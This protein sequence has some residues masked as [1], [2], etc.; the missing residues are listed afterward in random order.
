MRTP[1]SVGIPAFNEEKNIRK[2]LTSLLQQ[3]TERIDID[4]IIV[5]SS[6]SSDRTDMIVDEF[7]ER[8]EKVKLVKQEKREGKA[9]AINEFLKVARNDILV[10][11]SADTLPFEKTI[12][13]LC[14]PFRK[15]N[16]G[17]TGAHPV[18]TNDAES[19]MSYAVQFQWDLHHLI[20][21]RSPKCGEL[22]AFRRVFESLP[23]DTAVD[24]AWIEQEIHKRGYRV[25]YASEAL[26]YNKGPETVRDFLKQR[27]RITFGHLDL[28]RKTGYK[29]SSLSPI[30]MLSSF[31][32]IL[33]HQ[34]PRKWA[35]LF[36]VFSLE[37]LSRLLGYYDYLGNRKHEVWEISA[38]T[39]SLE[40]HVK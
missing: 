14:F 24:E 9:S 10:L 1:V 28:Y 25:V 23:E 33:K 12:E 40:I 7:S 17:M 21:L 11:E 27:R 8:E 13:S 32:E 34:S 36:P 5:V 31:L 16:V 30:L 39:K 35:L 2:L 22:I 19:F 37:G 15:D 20:A 26:V 18:P 29:V 4:E 3:K 38:T 6:G